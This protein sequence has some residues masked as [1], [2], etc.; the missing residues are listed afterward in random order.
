M[1][2][3]FNQFLRVDNLILDVKAG[4]E[5]SSAKITI[6]VPDELVEKLFA[7]FSSKDKCK[8]ANFYLCWKDLDLGENN[9]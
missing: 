1:K 3:K 7:C 4:S 6:A 2:N 5:K 9:D 8:I